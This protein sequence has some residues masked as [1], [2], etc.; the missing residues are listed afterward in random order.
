MEGLK[1]IAARNVR[2]A[3]TFEL[4]LAG[5][6]L[7]LPITPYASIISTFPRADC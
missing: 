2:L 3:E 4:A 5:I 7:C 6:Q 1:D